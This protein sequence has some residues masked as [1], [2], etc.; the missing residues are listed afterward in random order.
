VAL[1]RVI[2]DHEIVCWPFCLENPAQEA[3]SK[4]RLVLINVCAFESFDPTILEDI[5]LDNLV[6]NIADNCS[7][8]AVVLGLTR[9]SVV[10][11]L[12][13]H[14][15]VAAIIFGGLPGQALGKTSYRCA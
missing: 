2:A 4:F 9:P 5:V 1:G 13:E 8:I 10:D 15:N 14:E 6:L 12:T 3:S 11:A 7:S